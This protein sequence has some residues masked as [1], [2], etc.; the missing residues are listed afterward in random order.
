MNLIQGAHELAKASNMGCTV[1]HV[2]LAALP[3]HTYNY[4]DNET[5]VVLNNFTGDILGKWALQGQAIL[6]NLKDPPP[7]NQDSPDLLLV[8]KEA[9][10]S[11]TN[12]RRPD[13]DDRTLLAVLIMRTPRLQRIIEN[14]HQGD[15]DLLIR[16]LNET[17][18]GALIAT[19]PAA[20]D[21]EAKR[22]R[23]SL[24]DLLRE[25]SPTP[26]LRY[27][28]LSA[29]DVTTFLD[30]LADASTQSHVVVAVGRDGTLIDEIPK[31]VADRLA[32]KDTFKG[33]QT[34][35]NA[36]TGKLYW[37]NLRA[38]LDR[39]KQAN[40]PKPVGVL[41]AAWDQLLGMPDKPILLLDHI[42]AIKSEAKDQ[43]TEDLRAYIANPGRLL[44]FGVYHAPNHGDHTHEANLGRED[45][46]KTR[47]MTIYDGGLTKALLNQFYL[48]LW[49]KE[50]APRGYEFTSDAFDALIALEPGAWVKLRRTVLPGLVTEVV[51]DAMVTA[52]KGQEQ[53]E[54]TARGAL[55]AFA[56]L[57]TE[58]KGH[59]DRARFE[60]TLKKAEE[61]VGKL[62]RAPAPRGP[63][64]QFVNMFYEEEKAPPQDPNKPIKITSAHVMAEFIC[65]N[66]SEFHYE[67]FFPKGITKED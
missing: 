61:D 32:R 12:Q 65:H 23:A 50:E 22:A 19:K 16:K 18:S 35:L 56:E 1:E 17:P 63:L 52:F 21:E 4:L 36:Y 26:D 14:T 45:I 43:D 46:V 25:I 39:A 64:A 42:E 38:V 33:Q 6:D 55:Q 48:P 53:I 40:G 30:F 9:Q 7:A 27:V 24:A 31:V 47:A 3:P 34:S 49:G 29:V 44:V 59:K 57:R 13:D 8:L 51:A 66:V 20:E 11:A 41:R 54:A 10:A 28:G 62:I 58:A 2:F 67:G 60:P 37:L 15:L 5:V